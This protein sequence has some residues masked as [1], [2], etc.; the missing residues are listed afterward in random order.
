MVLTTLLEKIAGKQKARHEARKAD[1][2]GLVTQVAD[3]EEPD[4]EAV[5]KVLVENG[6]TLDDLRA[7][8]ELLL[9][10]RELRAAVDAMPALEKEQEA[11]RK[12]IADADAVV[13]KAKEECDRKTG[14]LYFRREQIKEALRD[15]SSARDK[16]FHSCDDEKLLA[17]LEEVDAE[18]TTL[19]ERARDL[20]NRARHMDSRAREEQMRAPRAFS[21]GDRLHHEELTKRYRHDAEVAR[22]SEAELHKAQD[23][24]VK[25]REAI[26]E[27]MREV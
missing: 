27:R 8:V 16:L 3:G 4:T 2:H 18:F 24:L 20:D 13:Q 11:L 15:G 6:K 17:E 26:E 25:R 10:R 5:E 12:Q 22:R 1:F 21:E 19:G 14:P 23:A 7:A 9:K